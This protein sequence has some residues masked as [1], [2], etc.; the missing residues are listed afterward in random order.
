MQPVEKL[1]KASRIIPAILVFLKLGLQFAIIF[2]PLLRQNALFLDLIYCLIPF[3]LHRGQ[4]ALYGLDL[5]AVYLI[6]RIASQKRPKRENDRRF[7]EFK[8]KLK[9]YLIHPSAPS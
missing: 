5:A 4:F 7:P 6:D 2:H 9:D 3:G 8:Q 1:K